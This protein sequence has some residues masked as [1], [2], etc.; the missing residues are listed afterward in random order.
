MREDGVLIWNV[1]AGCN[2]DCP[3]CF[4]GHNK[5]AHPNMGELDRRLNNLVNSI[6]GV[7]ELRLNGGELFDMPGFLDFFIP[8]ILKK[9]QHKI[10]VL[11]NLTC[12]LEEVVKLSE[13]TK[14]RLSFFS[15]SLHLMTKNNVS[16]RLINTNPYEYLEKAKKVKQAL[17]KNNPS[18]NYYVNCVLL[19]SKLELI[20]EFKAAYTEAGLPLFFQFLKTGLS[21]NLKPHIY[22]EEDLKKIEAIVGKEVT[23]N[24]LV[25]SAENFKGH[26]CHAGSKYLIIN[27]EG[28]AYVCHAATSNQKHCLGNL[29]ESKVNLFEKPIKCPY[30]LCTSGIPKIKGIIGSQTE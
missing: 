2:M 16:K 26:N 19:P 10:A 12:S 8:A 4:E 23:K 13:M 28:K 15:S 7:W 14:D 20:K 5:P 11:T 17:N 25:N 21:P 6:S 18:V 24:D 3:Y 29:S 9:S 30:Q 1:T 27:E 22:S